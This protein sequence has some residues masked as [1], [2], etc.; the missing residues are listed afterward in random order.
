MSSQPG[1]QIINQRPKGR[2]K[3]DPQI[4]IEIFRLRGLGKSI[5]G[6]LDTIGDDRVSRGTVAKYTKEFDNLS[7][8]T[9]ERYRPFE[10]H[11]LEEYGLPWESSAF[12]LGMWVRI[13]EYWADEDRVLPWSVPHL[14][15][16]AHQVRWWWRVHLAVPDG[17]NTM[18]IYIWAEQFSRREMF[19]GV[20]GS[21]LDMTD[22]EA[23]L[24]Y[25]PWAGPGNLFMYSQ[26]VEEKRIQQLPHAFH[27]FNVLDEIKAAG[28]IDLYSNMSPSLNP[29]HPERRP[30]QQISDLLEHLETFIS[31]QQ[32]ETE[33]A[34][35]AEI[36]GP[37]IEW[38]KLIR[39]RSE[40][41]DELI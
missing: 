5:D 30:S 35:Y 2:P 36:L 38:A 3:K 16:T 26:A 10:W 14:P 6:I 40:K 18:D 34:R 8:V 25:K 15:P 24:A 22:L 19:S 33:K 29:E 4:I 23:Y 21:P 31:R 32:N 11:R 37:A 27:E 20:M 7:E 13:Q 28:A 39:M 9:K 12:L 41:W 1:V 17:V